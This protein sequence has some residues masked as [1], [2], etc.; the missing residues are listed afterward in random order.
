MNHVSLLKLLQAHRCFLTRVVSSFALSSK[1]EE[2]SGS[3]T[4]A[5]SQPTIDQQESLF[6]EAKFKEK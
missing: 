3:L 6:P 2:T 1:E 5:I 4:S